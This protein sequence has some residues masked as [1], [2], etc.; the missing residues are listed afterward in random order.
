MPS[1][2]MKPPGLGRAFAIYT[3]SRVGLFVSFAALT[4]AAGV[5]GLFVLVI[6]LVVSAVA[7]YFLLARQRNAFAAALEAR[8]VRRTPRVSARTAAEDEIADRLVREQEQRP[9]EVG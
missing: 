1:G 2:D 3:A 9:R 8:V 6:P 4:Y 7:S 5:R